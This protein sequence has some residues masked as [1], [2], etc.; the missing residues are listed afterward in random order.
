MGS[1][2]I[3]GADNAVDLI[4]GDTG[5]CRIVRADPMSLDN[6]LPDENPVF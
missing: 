1:L 5:T 3:D 6:R 2:P 4:H